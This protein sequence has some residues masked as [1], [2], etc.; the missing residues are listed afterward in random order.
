MFERYHFA[1]YRNRFTQAYLIIYVVMLVFA[2]LK[3]TMFASP[4]ILMAIEIINGI[5]AVL[6][7]IKIFLVDQPDRRAI[8]INFVIAACFAGSA[9]FSGYTELSAVMLLIIGARHVP[10]VKIVRLFC[11]VTGTLIVIT[12]VASQVGLVTNLVY[13]G[14]GSTFGFNYTTDFG[15]HLFYWIM[16]LCYLLKEKMNRFV[17]SGILLLSLFVY[18][19]AGARTNAV[20]L[21]LTAMIFMYFYLKG[22]TKLGSR[23][24]QGLTLAMPL[25]AFGFIGL[26]VLY[27]LLPNNA[28]LMLFDRVVS[29]RLQLGSI[30]LAA[31]GVKL[32]GSEFIMVGFGRISQYSTGSNLLASAS[33]LLVLARFGMMA[34]MVLAFSNLV[35]AMRTKIKKWPGLYVLMIPVVIV[36]VYILLQ[37]IMGQRA[38]LAGD[39]N[40]HVPVPD[41]FFLDSSYVLLLI[42]YGLLAF[43]AT[44]LIFVLIARRAQR[45]RDYTLLIILALI[46]LQSMIEHHL[47]EIAYNPFILALLALVPETREILD[48]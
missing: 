35:M 4:G 12:I 37:L 41:Y 25:L 23:L 19:F 9:I 38:T 15:A 46:T 47:I 8:L 13:P 20:C 3:T 34:A 32:F 30:G 22:S 40:S 36:L 17:L 31:Y 1:Q 2:F 45:Q 33:N 21:L 16:A 28:I 27:Y 5:A 39:G 29:G 42:R 10:F 11:I 18:D 44:L 48:S 26:T 7:V 24:S 43:A 6:I 14:K